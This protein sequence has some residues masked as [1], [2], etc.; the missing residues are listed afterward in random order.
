MLNT[1]KNHSDFNNISYNYISLQRV[2]IPGNAEER[3]GN[4][5]Q[6]VRQYLVPRGGNFLIARFFSSQEL[7]IIMDGEYRSS[8]RNTDCNHFIDP[9]TRFSRLLFLLL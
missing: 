1:L 6:R 8:F 9:G 7:F 4:V 5:A 3:P 2:R